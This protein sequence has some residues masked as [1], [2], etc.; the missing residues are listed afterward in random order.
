M[1]KIVVITVCLFLLSGCSLAGEPD[2]ARFKGPYAQIGSEKVTL[3]I[4]DTDELRSKGLSGHSSLDD[5]KGMLFIFP[6][7]AVRSFWMKDM[8]FPLDI[9]WVND[10]KV[11]N[12][13]KNLPP[14]GTIPQKTYSSGL[15]INY[16]LELSAGW[17]DRHNLK[18]NDN[19][20]FI[21]G[22]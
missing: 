5:T 11:I 22:E 3:E 21:Y 10:G 9:V 8:L 6:T 19:I 18:V 16:V 15:P 1:K 20:K 12:I 14:E 2:V 13:S 7:K 4:A 17:C